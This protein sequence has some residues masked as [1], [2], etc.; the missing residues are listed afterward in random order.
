[1]SKP[2]ARHIKEPSLLG[3][4]I[5]Q[6]A[7]AEEARLR[8]EWKVR[9]MVVILSSARQAAANSGSGVESRTPES[10][11]NA[12]SPQ[13]TGSPQDSVSPQNDTQEKATSSDEVSD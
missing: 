1:M 7:L 11:Q 10:P 4:E 6:E 3:G 2:L 5:E 9:L 8:A 12:D 13:S